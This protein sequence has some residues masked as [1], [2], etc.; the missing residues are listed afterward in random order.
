MTGAEMK[1]RNRHGEDRKLSDVLIPAQLFNVH[2][3]SLGYSDAERDEAINSALSLGL[4]SLE[5]ARGGVPCYRVAKPSV[6]LKVKKEHN[7][8]THPIEMPLYT[9]MLMDWG[10]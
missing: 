4:F 6:I 2:V 5:V 3:R 1:K 10:D 8:M 7:G 9:L